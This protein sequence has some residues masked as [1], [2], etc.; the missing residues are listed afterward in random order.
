M[1]I[2]WK[3]ASALS[4]AAAGLVAN[5]VVNQGWKLITGHNP[6]NDSEAEAKTGVLEVV[7]FSA[8]SGV[9]VTLVQR[10]AMRKTNK[11]YGGGTKDPLS[12]D[13][14]EQSL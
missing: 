5:V 1:D 13:N 7:L 11:W 3:L 12:L 6:P 14:N 8:L 10:A 4:V 2:G 9:A